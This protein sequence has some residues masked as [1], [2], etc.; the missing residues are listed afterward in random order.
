[1]KM[2]R[3]RFCLPRQQVVLA[4]SF[5]GAWSRPLSWLMWP[6]RV[7]CPVSVAFGAIA[8]AL[9]C[10]FV[11]LGLTRHHKARGLSPAV[12]GGAGCGIPRVE[13]P[14]ASEATTSNL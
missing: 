12:G 10:D 9:A 5:F 11:A 14:T 13:R 6:C 1:M 8:G 3:R 2:V 4:F 7:V